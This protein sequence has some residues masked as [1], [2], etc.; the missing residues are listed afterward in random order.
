MQN[1]VVTPKAFDLRTHV[2]DPKTG[3]TIKMNH[4]KM[5]VSKTDGTRFE[6]PIGSGNYFNGAGDLIIKGKDPVVVKSV[7][8]VTQDLESQKSILAKENDELKAKIAALTASDSAKVQTATNKPV[9][10][11]EQKEKVQTK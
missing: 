7:E 5:E 3:E 4:Y 11:N 2:K 10:E 9:V 1:E 6:R 8:E